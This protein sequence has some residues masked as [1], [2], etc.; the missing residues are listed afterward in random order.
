MNHNPTRPTYL[1][2]A[3][4]TLVELLVVI[5]IIAVLISILLP[6]LSKATASARRLQCLSNLRQIGVA[7][8]SYEA[9]NNS[10]VIP[11]AT[12]YV[13]P[14]D[15]VDWMQMA[16]LQVL[17]TTKRRT[18]FYPIDP[19]QTWM[20]LICPSNTYA[21][22]A[23][24]GANFCYFVGVALCGDLGVGQPQP[25]KL[26]KV[27]FPSDKILVAE[28][29]SGG[30]YGASPDGSGS[31]STYNFHNNG[32]N[33]L[34]ADGSASFIADPWFSTTISGRGTTDGST[35][36]KPNWFRNTDRN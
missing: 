29:G 1:R 34:M 25:M 21:A 18:S 7:F 3:G 13:N 10:M 23:A 15:P 12:H 8:S 5:G 4:F 26:S 6:A 22:N 14:G 20:L 28:S 33:Y 24:Y 36:T 35:A 32:A 31:K 16:Q 9:E 2:Q 30:N 19:S 17:G 27:K 11:G